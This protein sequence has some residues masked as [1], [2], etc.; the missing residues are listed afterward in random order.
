EDYETPQ[1]IVVD[2]EDSIVPKSVDLDED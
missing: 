2:L 1:K